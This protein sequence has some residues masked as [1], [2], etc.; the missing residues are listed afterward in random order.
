MADAEVRGSA[1]SLGIPFTFH[2]YIPNTTVRNSIYIKSNMLII[3]LGGLR[4]W[5]AYTWKSVYR[6]PKTS[7]KPE[8]SLEGRCFTYPVGVQV[9]SS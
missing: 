6:E 5:V 1:V 3:G 2:Y 7:V 8:K 4:D 9:A